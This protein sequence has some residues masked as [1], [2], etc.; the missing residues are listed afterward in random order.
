MAELDGYRVVVV[1]NAAINVI[2]QRHCI[3]ILQLCSRQYAAMLLLFGTP[4]CPEPTSHS[5]RL[6]YGRLS[7]HVSIITAQQL[8]IAPT[9]EVGSNGFSIMHQG[10]SIS[11]H[12]T[13]K[14]GYQSRNSGE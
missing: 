12:H 11:R 14:I 1:Y 9:K 6:E 8:G 13:N 10:N 2:L 5:Y 7:Q 3:V 4:L